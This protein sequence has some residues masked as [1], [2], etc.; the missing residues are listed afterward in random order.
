MKIKKIDVPFAQVANQVLNDSRLSWKAKGIFA[1]IQSK[2]EVWDFSSDRM[3]EDATDGRKS[4]LAGINELIEVG[5]LTR[6]KNADGTQDMELKLPKPESPKGDVALEPESL[7]G[8]VPFGHGAQTAPISNKESLVIKNSQ[9]ERAQ[10]FVFPSWIDPV[11]WARWEKHRAEKRSKLTPTTVESQVKKLEKCKDFYAEVIE[12]SIGNGWLGLFP[13][14]IDRKTIEGVKRD[15]Q[16]EA[17]KKP[18]EEYPDLTDEQREINRQRL[19]EI[20]EGTL[21]IGALKR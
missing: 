6:K 20:K 14:K 18:E 21:Q 1:Y 10:P 16:I 9:K 12:L 19:R 7:N 15:K 17:G 8:T 11:V 2:P 5:Y 3:A 13:E 4:T